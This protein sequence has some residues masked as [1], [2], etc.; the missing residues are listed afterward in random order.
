MS[1]RVRDGA[2]PGTVD[3]SAPAVLERGENTGY[4]AE[5]RAAAAGLLARLWIP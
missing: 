3:A 2:L 5:C 1:L 4:P